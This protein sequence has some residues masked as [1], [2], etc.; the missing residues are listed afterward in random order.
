MNEGAYPL[1]HPCV[2]SLR[3]KHIVIPGCDPGSHILIVAP[4]SY[5]VV[6]Q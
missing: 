2:A 3:T 6:Y 4:F 1:E 5:R